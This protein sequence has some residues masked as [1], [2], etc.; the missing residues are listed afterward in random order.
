LRPIIARSRATGWARPI[1][2]QPT[3]DHRL[4]A[5]VTDGLS[6]TASVVIPADE[7]RFRFSRSGG[8][9]GQNV[10]TRDTRVELVF[11][12]ASSSALGPRQRARALQRLGPRLDAEG[13]L[14]VV[15]A[16]ERSQ[17]R[18]RELALER[19]RSILAEAL[20]P[21]PPVR[22]A[23]RPSKGADD[24]RLAAKRARSRLKQGRAAVP[25]D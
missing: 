8:P 16:D 5:E 14:R 22:R 6:V 20:R 11:D 10:N 13:R 1:A 15:A 12:V 4:M 19:L 24:A 17:A 18:N 2:G 9:G 25:E 21:D 3:C 23:T 7:L